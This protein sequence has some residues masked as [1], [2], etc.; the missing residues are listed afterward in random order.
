MKSSS[1]RVLI[2]YELL[3]SGFE[4]VY[5]GEK[6]DEMIQ[7]NG[8]PISR[9]TD[10]NGNIIEKWSVWTWQSDPSKWDEE[11]NHVNAM[12]KF[13]GSLDDNTRQ[14]RAHIGSLVLCEPGIPVTID[15]LLAAVGRGQFLDSPLHNGCWCCGMWWECR[16]TQHGQPKAMTAI[17]QILLGYLEGRTAEELSE[18]FKDAKG[19]I[20]RTYGWLPLVAD[21]S[22]VQRLMIERMLLPFE[23]FTARNADY[24]HVNHNCFEEGGRGFRLDS[25]IS[26]LSGLPK[27]HPNYK[28]EFRENLQT[29]D[30]P[31]KTELYKICCAIAHGLH[32]LSDCHHSAFR[33]IER[34]V[35][36][37]GTLS[38]GIPQRPVGTE[39]QRLATSLFGYLIGLDN[40]LLGT[41]MQFL[42]M[43]L[44]YADLGFE[45]K[46]EI[47][48]VYTYLGPDRTSVKEWLAACLWKTLYGAGNPC[49][50]II[51][52]DFIRRA[53]KLGVSTRG[54]I[55]R[56]LAEDR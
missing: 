52:R 49:G 16:G 28:Q 2:P 22:Q 12:Q 33:W 21:L 56:Q 8:W 38:L 19:F 45:P 13:L 20:R 36:D 4:A 5:T 7:P 46:H 29:I 40:W 11:I 34:W 3:S 50:L 30:D 51:Q 27:I 35:H 15:N 53:E 44:G 42:L 17:E 14:I 37:I 6:S 24:N 41:S 9:F 25:E 54:W 43:D 55:D 31:Q 10:N 39:R 48:R 18:Q 23:W 47:L 32:G 26:K 1:K